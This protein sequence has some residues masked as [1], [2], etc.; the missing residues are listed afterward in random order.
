MLYQEKNIT[1][2]VCLT[3]IEQLKHDLC[4]RSY[5]SQEEDGSDMPSTVQY[6]KWVKG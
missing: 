2:D 3:A 5:V 6:A 1:I 4:G